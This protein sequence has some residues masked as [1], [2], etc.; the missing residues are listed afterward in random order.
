[1]MRDEVCSQ[2]TFIRFINIEAMIANDHPVRTVNWMC[3][4]VLPTTN[5]DFDYICAAKGAP[6]I[7]PD[8]LFKAK[9]LQAPYTVRSDRQLCARLQTDRAGAVT[10][11]SS[12]R[13]RRANTSS[14]PGTSCAWLN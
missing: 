1:M 10:A 7:A 9:V 14:S 13:T 8:T 2:V 3:G 12:A 6:S 4:A 11:A 5:A